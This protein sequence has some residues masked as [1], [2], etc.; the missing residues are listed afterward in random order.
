MESESIASALGMPKTHTYSYDFHELTTHNSSF[1][2]TPML[3]SDDAFL[4]NIAQMIPMK[5]IAA[6]EEVP[7]T[8]V[9]SFHSSG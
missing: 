6:A 2:K 9:S 8:Y 7:I 5:R 1:I 3:P 4:T